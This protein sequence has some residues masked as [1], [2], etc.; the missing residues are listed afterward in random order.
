MELGRGQMATKI[1]PGNIN[2]AVESL[3]FLCAR[4]E[5]RV[6]KVSFIVVD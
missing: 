1:S 4:S 5:L 3:L 6:V 2:K